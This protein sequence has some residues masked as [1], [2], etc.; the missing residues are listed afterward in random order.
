MTGGRY[1]E[2]SAPRFIVP[3]GS[4]TRMGSPVSSLRSTSSDWAIKVV[5]RMKAIEP[6]PNTSGRACSPGTPTLCQIHPLLCLRHSTAS[7]C[8][9][10]ATQI[11]TGPFRNSQHIEQEMAAIGKKLGG[12]GVLLPAHDRAESEHK[13]LDTFS[14]CLWLQCGPRVEATRCGHWLAHGVAHLRI[15]R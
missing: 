10:R 12:I 7:A 13:L 4:A 3:T 8:R 9:R 15:G 1:G 5:P 2:A 11:D 6:L 14:D